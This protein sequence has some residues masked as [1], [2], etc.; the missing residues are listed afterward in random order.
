MQVEDF[1]KWPFQYFWY[2]HNKLVAVF[3]QDYVA[4]WFDTKKCIQAMEGR[5]LKLPGVVKVETWTKFV[6]EKMTNDK[7]LRENDFYKLAE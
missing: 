6:T 4:G 1:A 5:H 7:T 3:S 2:D